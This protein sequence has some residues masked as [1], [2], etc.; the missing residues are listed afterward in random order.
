MSKNTNKRHCII[1]YKQAIKSMALTQT[2]KSNSKNASRSDAL[3]T[4]MGVLAVLAS[5]LGAPQKAVA[6]CDSPSNP[7]AGTVVT[8]SGTTTGTFTV[9]NVTDVQV[10]NTGTWNG[11]GNQ[12]MMLF[13]N[14]GDIT[15]SRLVNEGIMNWTNAQNL[16]DGT[17]G[18]L[19]M[20]TINSAVSAEAINAA[21]AQLNIT[22]DINPPGSSISAI[23]VQARGAN[24]AFITRNHGDINIEANTT[25]GTNYFGIITRA[26]RSVLINNTGNINIDQ[27]VDT[28]QRATGIFGQ[29]AVNGSAAPTQPVEMNIINTG[30]I[31]V[32]PDNQNLSN[33]RGIVAQQSNTPAP[34][35]SSVI[36]ITNTGVINVNG[37]SSFGV[38]FFG[39]FPDIT[40]NLNNS[41]QIL[42]AGDTSWSFVS[43]STT[44]DANIINTGVM[45]GNI[46]TR[47]GNDTLNQI[48]GTITGNIELGDGD[49]NIA[50]TGGSIFGDIDTGSGNDGLNISGGILNGNTNLG[51]GDNVVAVSGGSIAGDITTGS[52]TDMF[53]IT[54]GLLTGTVSSTAGNNEFNLV[55]GAINGS[56][57]GGTDT[58]TFNLRGGFNPAG[59]LRVDGGVGE[60]YVNINGLTLRGFTG[61]DDASKGVNFVGIEKMDLVNNATLALT[62]DLF[63]AGA[64]AQ[65]SIDSSST[66]QLAGEPL[67]M[68]T[69]HGNVTNAGL[70]NF[71][72]GAPG[73]ST[74]IMG[75]LVNATAA[76]LRMDT[77]LGDDSSATDSL[78]V[79]GDVSG[80]AGIFINQVGGQGAATTNGILLVQVDGQSAA[81]N[82]VLLNGPLQAGAFE[83]VL[84]QGSQVDTNDWYL[85]SSVVVPEPEPKPEPTEST[86]GATARSVSRAQVMP[87]YR[88]AISAYS[89]T[90]SVNADVGMMQVA[91]LHQRMG[92]LTAQELDEGV[93]WIRLL[94]ERVSGEGKTRFN[95]EQDSLGVQFGHDLWNKAHNDNNEKIRSGVMVHHVQSD[96]KAWDSVRPVAGLAQ[97]TGNIDT[98]TVGVGLYRTKL[99]GQTSYTDTVLQL[100]NIKNKFTDS[101]GGEG[102]QSG[103]QLL[104]SLEK[105]KELAQVNNYRI[106]GQGQLTGMYTRYGEFE[107]GFSSIDSQTFSTVR[108][109]LGVRVHNG[110][111]ASDEPRYYGVANL[112]RDLSKTKDLKVSDKTHVSQ[113]LNVSEEF[114]QTYAQLGVGAQIKT[115]EKSWIYS[116]VRYEEGIEN[117]QSGGKINIG[118]KS[119]F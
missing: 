74:T 59:L 103:V 24:S 65:L 12:Y 2:A 107:D 116:D 92:D 63:D 83:Y 67:G 76:R 73:D 33:A 29:V 78:V 7:T 88:P 62:G 25:G 114:D 55:G 80:Q 11:N 87:L 104:A 19:T 18:I 10:T 71:Q 26:N 72:D 96:T 9:T 90:R 95:Y 34:N 79:R 94:G 38:I 4:S 110:E 115:G 81:D 15:G 22:L 13:M 100:N 57:F 109:R 30:N 93:D 60:D 66:L 21:G 40:V 56:V 20:F 69:I 84:Q 105:G 36:N 117:R 17:R 113:T 31:N 35:V 50:I 6:A 111:A 44:A 32:S 27:T 77:E 14:L 118:F 48:A 42:T 54:G 112:I 106:E 16:D 46:F 108:A 61:D 64:M 58:D 47:A 75:N 99:N 1:C 97:D 102:T 5:L 85:T 23:A 89:V 53:S 37:K 39:N 49:N 82:F 45:L 119:S 86:G 52:G 28:T 41:G 101:Y 91:T 68:F 98:K 51:D 70:L 43:N 3:R 8:C